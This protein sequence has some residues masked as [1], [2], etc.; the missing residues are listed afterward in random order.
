MQEQRKKLDQLLDVKANV[1]KKL[2]TVS[3]DLQSHEKKTREDQ[4]QLNS[5]RQSLAQMSE[6]QREVRLMQNYKDEKIRSAVEKKLSF[7]S[8]PSAADGVC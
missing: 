8:R 7:I 6:S 5:L 1:E 4:Q 2:S 3:S